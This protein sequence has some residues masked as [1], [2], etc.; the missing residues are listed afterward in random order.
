MMLVLSIVMIGALNSCNKTGGSGQP[1]NLTKEEQKERAQVFTVYEVEPTFTQDNAQ[2]DVKVFF[3]QPVDDEEAVKI[4]PSAVVD[5]YN[6]T[7]TYLGD[8]KYNFQLNNIERKDKDTEIE[9]ELNGKPLNS[10]TQ[11]SKTLAVPAEGKFKLMDYK[12]DKANSI[13]TLYFSQPLKQ[14]NIDGYLSISPNMGYRSVIVDNK[15]VIYFDKSN[16]YSYQ[17][18][19]VNLTIG[20][21]IKD[22]AGN[23]LLKEIELT[24]DLTDLSPKVRWTEK[25]VIVP[26]VS[27]ATI[28]FDAICLNSVV[29]RIVKV[30]DGNILSFYQ[31][32]DLDDTW[33]IRNAGRL[34][35]KVR[36]AL[37]NPTPNQWRSFPITLSDYVDVKAGDM[38]QLILDFGPADYAYATEESKQ[39]TLEDDALEARYWDGQAGDF[40][41]HDYDGDWDDPLSTSYYNWVEEKKNV[42]ITDLALTAKMGSSDAIDVFVF[43]ISDT[44]PVSGATVEAYNYQRQLIASG[45]TDSKGHVQLSCENR[46]AFVIAK[47]NKGG[48]SIIK[49]NDGEALS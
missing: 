32:N 11:I 28:Y 12:V 44:K 34:E 48:Q 38:Y 16:V 7:T 9:L 2:Y 49:T 13:V 39:L 45:R 40:K 35:K 22:L 14:R 15:L 3:S 1:G 24:F 26:E 30:Y 31:N 29:L 47:N 20:S 4:F 41:H 27:E 21:G 46:P 43:Q 33:G 10:K 6:V 5:K 8:R 36:I 23:S 19:N 17:L 37:D 42:I 25:G 18:E